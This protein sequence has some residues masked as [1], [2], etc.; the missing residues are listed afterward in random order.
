MTDI[1][2]EAE[3]MPSRRVP[4][5]PAIGARWVREAAAFRAEAAPRAEF[6]LR[7]GDTARQSLDLFPPE[8]GGPAPLA[9]FIHGGWWCETDKSV[10]SHMARGLNAHGI[11]VAVT[12]YDL[13]PNVTL[14]VI[15]AEMRG[16]CLY[17]KERAGRRI[18]VF[19]HSAGGH[20]AAAMASSVPEAVQGGLAISGAFD[21]VPLLGFSLNREWR[22]DHATARA[23]SPIHWRK[24]GGAFEAWVGA[25]ESGGFKGQSR[26][27]ASAWGVPYVEAAGADHF[28]AIDP[29]ADPDSAMVA[30]VAGMARRSE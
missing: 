14:A 5:W 9:L 1:D 30:R 6:D 20:L 15:V 28:T 22:L 11:A 10:Y 21:L 8:G 17:L 29:L 13:C 26:A 23:L 19:G 24:P 25:L 2:L 27:L 18:A 16:A 12:S 3:Y 4:H 7:F